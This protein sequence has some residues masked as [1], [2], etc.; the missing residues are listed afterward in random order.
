MYFVALQL[1]NIAQ[2]SL[3]SIFLASFIIYINTSCVYLTLIF[4]HNGK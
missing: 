3:R 1:G 4:S 2:F